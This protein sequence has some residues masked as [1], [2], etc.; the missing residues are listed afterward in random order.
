MGARATFNS[1]AGWKGKS[2][3]CPVI[4]PFPSLLF[5]GLVIKDLVPADR[6]VDQG[7]HTAV[8][9]RWEFTATVG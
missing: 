9:C 1:H 2:A 3:S 8:K 7:L 5:E 6:H 4:R